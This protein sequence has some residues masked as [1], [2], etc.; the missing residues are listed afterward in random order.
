LAALAAPMVR[1]PLALAGASLGRATAELDRPLV[2]FR[3]HDR[4]IAPAELPGLLADGTELTGRLLVLVPDA[5]GDEYAWAEGRDETGATYAERL[6][7]LLRWTPVHTRLDAG[8]PT[9]AGLELASL[10]QRLVA[11]WP[12]PVE[13]IVL[14]AAG[15]GGL[16]VRAATSMRLPDATPWTGVVTEVVGLG[17]PR[18]AAE[19]SRLASDIGRRIDE[20]LAGIVQ[21]E[22]AFLGL[23]PVVRADHLMVTER[24]VAPNAFGNAF[25]WLLW[26]RHRRTPGRPRDVVDLFPGAESFEL[27]AAGPLTNRGDLHDALLRWLV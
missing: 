18:Y 7:A 20:Q 25:G 4:D 5:G 26:G 1:T 17:V 16:A 21:A 8:S 27:P 14:L 22:P 15:N 19:P 10:L 2:A 13:R 6:Q 9:D 24:M 12:V 23:E 11:S 3:H